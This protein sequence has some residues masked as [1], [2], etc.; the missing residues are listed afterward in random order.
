VLQLVNGE[1]IKL[2]RGDVVPDD[3]VIRTLQSGNVQFKRTAETIDLGPQTQIQ[4]FDKS[5]KRYTTVRQYFGSVS[6]EAEVR[7]VQHFEVQTPYLAAVVKG[8]K[9]VV[10]SGKDGAAVKVTRG[11][12]AVEDNDSH[13]TTL[14]AVGQM[15]TTGGGGVLEVSGKGDLPVVYAANGKPVT[16]ANGSAALTPKQA[17][18]EARASALAAGATAK[19]AEKAAEAAEKDAKQARKDAEQAAAA[20]A[21]QQAIAAGASPKHA[22]KEAKQA[23]KAA[24]QSSGSSGSGNSGSGSSGSSGSGSGDSGSGDSDSGKGKKKDKD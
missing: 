17:A 13:Q 5:G 12:V 10:T 8:T 1:W 4:I 22:E 14:L 19:E 24:E 18:A 7:N 6:V 21:Y 3:R 9:F 16:A 15:A 11:H 23:E 20:I 2:K